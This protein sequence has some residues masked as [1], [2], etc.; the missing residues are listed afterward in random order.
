MGRWE[1]PEE[2]RI[3]GGV[4]GYGDEDEE[5]VVASLEHDKSAVTNTLALV[6][7]FVGARECWSVWLSE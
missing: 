5:G 7:R 1:D 3:E 6:V 4:K 2:R